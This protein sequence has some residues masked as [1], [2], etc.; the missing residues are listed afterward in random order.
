MDK[1]L[2]LAGIGPDSAEFL[3]AQIPDSKMLDAA[4]DEFAVSVARFKFRPTCGRIFSQ[5]IRR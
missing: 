3:F 2:R 4:H 1:A 5:H